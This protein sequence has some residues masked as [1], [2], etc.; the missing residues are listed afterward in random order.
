M[1]YS[2]F[3]GQWLLFPPDELSKHP[4]IIK[5]EKECRKARAEMTAHLEAKGYTFKP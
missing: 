2:D 1:V 3:I 4:Y 5:S